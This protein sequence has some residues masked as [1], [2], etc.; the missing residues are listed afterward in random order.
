MPDMAKRIIERA[1]TAGFERCGIVRAD[2]MAGYAKKLSDRCAR[3]PES[4]SSLSFMRPEADPRET[5][6]WVRS[7]V[8]CSWRYGIYRVPENLNGRIGKMYLFDERRD[9]KADGWRAGT[10][11]EKFLADDLGMRTV[12]ARTAGR[13]TSGITAYR[14]AALQAGLGTIRK[15]N[16]FYGDHGSYYV[17]Q[18]FLVDQDL[19]FI[20]T[21]RFI[22]PCSDG[23]S[24]CIKN[25]P[26]RSLA[27]PYAMSRVTC[28][29]HLTTQESDEAAFDICSEGTGQWI[30]GCDACQ[31]ACPF[32]K[33]QLPGSAEFHDIDE[34]SREMSL[35]GLLAME[36]KRMGE[37]L[38]PKFWYI[39]KNDVWKWKRNVLNAMHSKWNDQYRPALDLACRDS[40]QRVRARAEKLRSHV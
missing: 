34:L 16:F 28:V 3:F 6:P 35:E 36:Y 23:C 27:E 8:I 22:I 4:A 13:L 25:C 39:K 26:T 5:F 32:N 30:Y 1:V 18:A 24:L 20:H 17:L 21:P 33:G 12:S 37:L 15:N 31:D 9:E 11:F 7:V 10:E 40:D 14:W 2:A 29:S 19:E 38:S